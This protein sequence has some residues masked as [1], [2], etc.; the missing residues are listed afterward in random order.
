MISLRIEHA[1]PVW[2]RH[3]VISSDY[4]SM[5]KD[6]ELIRWDYDLFPWVQKVLEEKKD[7]ITCYGFTQSCPEILAFTIFGEAKHLVGF[8]KELEKEVV[9]INSSSQSKRR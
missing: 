3:I 8:V 7:V 4:E 5:M 1:N 6:G 2:D 9:R